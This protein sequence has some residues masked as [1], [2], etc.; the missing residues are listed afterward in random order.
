M[1]AGLQDG[2]WDPRQS[3]LQMGMRVV[4]SFAEVVDAL[5]MQWKKGSALLPKAFHWAPHWVS[6]V[7]HSDIGFHCP[8]VHWSY[9]SHLCWAWSDGFWIYKL[10]CHASRGWTDH[11]EATLFID[12]IT[13]YSLTAYMA[14]Y[15][16]QH[17]HLSNIIRYIRFTRDRHDTSVFKIQKN[18]DG[19]TSNDINMLSSNCNI[20]S[21]FI[22][23]IIKYC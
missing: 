16:K 13:S 3:H 17:R 10:E 7:L 4:I 8:Q 21:K 6:K 12:S 9:T 20:I 1:H 5:K 14:A 2:R 19:K 22:I 18:R 11:S 23:V 15:M